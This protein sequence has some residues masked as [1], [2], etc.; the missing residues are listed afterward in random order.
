MDLL[1]WPQLP[2]KCN[3]PGVNILAVSSK[4]VPKWP[5]SLSYQKKDGHAGPCPSFFWYDTDFL[6]FFEKKN[7]DFLFLKSRCHTK[8]RTGARDSDIMG[9][10]CVMHTILASGNCWPFCG[11]TVTCWI[12]Y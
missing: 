5:E 1:K 9:P 3:K 2:E 10:F 6:E 11:N 7:L 4:K 12:Q 8:R